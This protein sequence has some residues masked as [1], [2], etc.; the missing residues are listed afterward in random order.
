[1]GR[2]IRELGWDRRDI[3]ISTKIFFG[4]NRKEVHNTRGLSRKH[5]IEG[6]HAS[7]ERLGLDYVDIIFAHR[8]DIT[9]PMEEVVRA[10]NWLIDSEHKVSLWLWLTLRQ[11]GLLLGYLGVVCCP[12]HPGQGDCSPSQPR[13]SR[14]RAAPLLDAPP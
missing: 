1:M 2:V 12:D 6:A 9:T 14:R 4:T 10:F 5:I 13:W 8:P 3:I 7:L 11:Q